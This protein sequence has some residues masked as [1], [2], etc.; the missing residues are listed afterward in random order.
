MSRY[1]EKNVRCVSTERQPGGPNLGRD[2]KVAVI[3]LE[4][5]E[6][7]ER[8]NVCVCARDRVDYFSFGDEKK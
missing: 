6:S 1:V 3:H 8:V 4:V 5:F 2:V 7:L